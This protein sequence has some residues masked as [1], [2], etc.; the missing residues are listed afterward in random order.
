M[1][2]MAIGRLLVLGFGSLLAIASSG[3]VLDPLAQPES[4]SS[5]VSSPPPTV[6]PACGTC[7]YDSQFEKEQTETGLPCSL[8]F[9]ENYEFGYCQ[10]YVCQHGYYYS[11]TGWSS[12]DCAN[13]IDGSYPIC[14]G[15]SCTP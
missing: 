5:G 3:A 11:F 10:K 1:T 4:S 15:G 2:A 12:N 8:I 9:S 14:P 13:H 7:S 6:K